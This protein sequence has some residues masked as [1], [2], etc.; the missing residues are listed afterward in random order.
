MTNNQLDYL[1][2][3]KNPVL[4]KRSHQ[5][6]I[7]YLGYYGGKEYTTKRLSMYPNETSLDFYGGTRYDGSKVVGRRDYTPDVNY[8]RRIVEEIDN[9]TF[10]DAPVR[11]AIKFDI[12]NNI[13]GCDDSVDD[14]LK[15]LNTHLTV[16]GWA[17]L[18]IDIPHYDTTQEISIKE[19][20]EMGIRPYW[21]AVDPR[22][23]VD[24]SIDRYGIN[25][26]LED[27]YIVLNQGPTAP[28][29]FTKV[30]RLW[31]KG[32]VTTISEVE[33]DKRRKAKYNATTKEININEV[34]FILVGK[35]SDKP[36]SFDIFESLNKN[37]L[38][39]E[40]SNKQIYMDVAFPQPYITASMFER[41]YNQQLSKNTLTTPNN[42]LIYDES[43]AMDQAFALAT[44]TKRP[45]V[46]GE[47]E[48][49]IVAQMPT[50]LEQVRNE[51][52]A[53]LKNL[54]E[55]SGIVLRKEGGSNESAIAK[56]YDLIRVQSLVSERRR[57]LVNAERV[58][59]MMSSDW[60]S[61]FAS[62][63]VEFDPVIR[64]EENMNQTNDDSLYTDE[65]LS[66]FE[67]TIG[68]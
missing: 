67:S 45:L 2:N 18:K 10:H 55:V 43:R 65:E 41:L 14:V 42:D 15:E 32:R 19:K 6:D 3:R 39:L 28:T 31:E 22:K 23:V 64:I 54:M 38:D 36:H 4:Q 44:G 9:L 59:I 20:E 58:A 56:A 7:N 61:D 35:I 48:S 12:I 24:W 47:G 52:Q 21:Y 26:V 29:K 34:P 60:D 66:M 46:L 17:W 33:Q 51:I 16:S 1:Y 68:A 49:P 57:L 8:L 53:C 27:D 37:I 40:S 30:R 25:W 11:D 50:G 13:N 63:N 62:Y 5:L